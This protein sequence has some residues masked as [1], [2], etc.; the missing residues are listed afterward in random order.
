[1]YAKGSQVS[2]RFSLKYFD[3]V[4]GS[5]VTPEGNSCINA[6]SAAKNKQLAVIMKLN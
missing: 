1:M 3:T 6:E 5:F 2:F 4:V